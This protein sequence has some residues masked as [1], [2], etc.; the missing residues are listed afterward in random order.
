[1][2]KTLLR[3]EVGNIQEYHQYIHDSK[4]NIHKCNIMASGWGRR[5][6]KAGSFFVWGADVPTYNR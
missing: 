6:D 3:I 2:A 1:M 4:S 5:E